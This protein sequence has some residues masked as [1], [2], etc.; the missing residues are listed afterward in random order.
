MRG[1][2]ARRKFPLTVA[3]PK[4]RGTAEA[5]SQKGGRGLG[6]WKASNLTHQMVEYWFGQ[7]VQDFRWPSIGGWV[8]K[9]NVRLYA[10]STGR[11]QTHAH[12]VVPTGPARDQE[13]S[14]QG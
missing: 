6:A 3:G 12:G 2:P 5:W 9:S 10:R 7:V 11:L 14:N 1:F 4:S 8:P 13:K